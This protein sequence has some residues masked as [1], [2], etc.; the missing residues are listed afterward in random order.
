MF[1]PGDAGATALQATSSPWP[2]SANSPSKGRLATW[3]VTTPPRG[4]QAAGR[5]RLGRGLPLV[6]RGMPRAQHRLRP[7]LLVRWPGP[8][9]LLL[10]QEQDGEPAREAGGQI[11]HGAQVVESTGLVNLD[12]W[13]AGSRLIVRREHPIPA[14]SSGCSTPSKACAHRVHHR[15]AQLRAGRPGAAPSPPGPS[16]TDHLGHQACGLAR[17]PLDGAADNDRWM[18]RTFCA[19]TCSAGHLRPCRRRLDATWPWTPD[20]LNAIDHLKTRLRQPPPSVSIHPG[21]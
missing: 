13:P 8:R 4:P 9:R 21:L 20:L 19:T 18:Q 5:H 15:H 12:A 17:L 16:R 11:R 6:R 7:R 1:R 3:L 2:P 14:P 10:V